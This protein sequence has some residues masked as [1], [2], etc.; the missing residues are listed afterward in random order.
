MSDKVLSTKVRE[1]D[2]EEIKGLAEEE[3]KTVSG[4]L[5]ELLDR[6]IQKTKGGWDDPCFGSDP[7]DDEPKKK[8]AEVDEILYGK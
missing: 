8:D 6:E 3:G 1:E 5:R 2:V 7:R 4:F